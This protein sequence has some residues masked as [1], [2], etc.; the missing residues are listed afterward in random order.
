[1]KKLPVFYDPDKRRRAVIL[2]FAA[3]FA[4]VA[5]FSI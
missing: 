2:R 4:V 5:A 1:M 3:T